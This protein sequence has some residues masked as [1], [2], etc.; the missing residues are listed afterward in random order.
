MV[1]GPGG[2]LHECVV[3]DYGLA[4]Q[5]CPPMGD[6][7]MRIQKLLRGF[8]RVKRQAFRQDD[9][10]AVVGARTHHQEDG[11]GLDC[12]VNQ[13]TPDADGHRRGGNTDSTGRGVGEITQRHLPHFVQS[14]HNKSYR[15][16]GLITQRGSWGSTPDQAHLGFKAENVGQQAATL[17]SDPS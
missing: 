1:V 3:D 4:W 7:A 8:F 11:C 6:I 14:S 16:G 5:Q 9:L 12:L 10:L 2:D 17:S 13:P 15:E